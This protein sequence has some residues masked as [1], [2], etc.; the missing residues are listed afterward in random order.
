MEE[1]K[2]LLFANDM[3]AYMLDFYQK[4]PTANKFSGVVRYKIKKISSS[5][6]YK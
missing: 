3:I 4:T 6:I 5:P 2:E 1:F